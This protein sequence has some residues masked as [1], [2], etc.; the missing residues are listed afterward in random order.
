MNGV[1]RPGF[2]SQFAFQRMPCARQ[3]ACARFDLEDAQIRL[4]FVLHLENLEE[5]LAFI[6]NHD[7]TRRRL[8]LLFVRHLQNGKVRLAL[9]RVSNTL[10]SAWFSYFTTRTCAMGQFL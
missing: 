8:G 6:V 3:P 2:T 10:A 4:G 7:A 9:L 1:P 5:S